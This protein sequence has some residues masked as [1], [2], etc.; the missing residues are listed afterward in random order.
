[1]DPNNTSLNL[2]DLPEQDGPLPLDDFEVTDVA[3]EEI[4]EEALRLEGYRDYI[5]ETRGDRLTAD[6]M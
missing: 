6:E 2:D 4:Q 5:R 3:P 1:M